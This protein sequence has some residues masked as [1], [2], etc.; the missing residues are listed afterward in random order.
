MESQQSTT[1]SPQS[2]NNVNNASPGNSPTYQRTNTTQTNQ[3]SM[4]TNLPTRTLHLQPNIPAMATEPQNQQRPNGY[5][6]R[7]EREFLMNEPPRFEPSFTFAAQSPDPT[8]TKHGSPVQPSTQLS[9]FP[10]LVQEQTHLPE[11]DRP[12]LSSL[13]RSPSY[14]HPISKYKQ[15]PTGSRTSKGM[16]CWWGEKTN[17]ECESSTSPCKRTHPKSD[18]VYTHKRKCNTNDKQPLG[19]PDRPNSPTLNPT[20]NSCME[21]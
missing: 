2:P 6:M 4:P 8:K 10:E 20:E 5:L 1:H 3:N 21:L 11:P 19:E 16:F 14:L 7:E 12:Y 17:T 15:N 18:A 9:S 13:P